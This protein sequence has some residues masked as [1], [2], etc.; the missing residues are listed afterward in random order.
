MDRPIAIESK[1]AFLSGKHSGLTGLAGVCRRD[2]DPFLHLVGYPLNRF[3]QLG[4]II[5]EVSSPRPIVKLKTVRDSK[6]TP[7]NLSPSI[8]RTICEQPILL[9]VLGIECRIQ[10][11]LATGIEGQ[12]GN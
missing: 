6:V 1:S 10:R 12:F 3:C 9:D 5:V 8:N 7:F 11:I 2:D 4:I